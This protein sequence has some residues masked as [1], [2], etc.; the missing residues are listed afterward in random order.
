MFF[1]TACQRFG[2][3]EIDTIRYATLAEEHKLNSSRTD[4]YEFISVGARVN[5]NDSESEMFFF[6]LLNLL[7]CP[8][9]PA[10][11]C[12]HRSDTYTMQVLVNAIY[13]KGTWQQEFDAKMTTPS[14]FH[15][16]E[17]SGTVKVPLMLL[18]DRTASGSHVVS[19]KLL[20]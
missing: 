20:A 19:Q 2:D 5:I 13:F 18:K 1:K 4:R 17:K 12:L 15:L 9:F 16:L 11:F 3:V 7:V 8:S 10:H 6:L 14:D